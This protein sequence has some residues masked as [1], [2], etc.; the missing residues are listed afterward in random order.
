MKPG[1]FQ[2]TNYQMGRAV[3]KVMVVGTLTE[4][5][6]RGERFPA[7]GLPGTVPS[8]AAKSR[9]VGIRRVGD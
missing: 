1:T 3:T 7:L 5:I 4:A 2:V 6:Q 9:V 8:A